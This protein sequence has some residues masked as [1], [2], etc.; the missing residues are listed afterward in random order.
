MNPG[1]WHI[2]SVAAAQPHRVAF[3][4]DVFNLENPTLAAAFASPSADRHEVVAQAAPAK[5]FVVLDE[6]AAAAD[7]TLISR[8]EQRFARG[9][10]P[11]LAA[12]LKLPGGEASKNDPAHLDT[13]YRAMLDCG[14]DRRS[15]VLAI[16]GGA[17]LDTAG[18]AAATMH[19]GVRL[20]RLPTTTLAQCDSGVGVKNAVNRFGVK[21][22]TGTFAVPWAVVN[23]SRFLRTLPDDVWR[24]GFAEVVKVA[25][26]KDAELFCWLEEHADALA[27]RDEPLAEHAWQRSAALHLQ[28]IAEAPPDGGGDPF[29]AD[30]ARPLDFGHW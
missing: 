10:L 8:I 7:F 29:E 5:T 13:L 2:R 6:N 17:L 22:A 14:I 12:T 15:Y 26:L 16:G 1:S 30:Q 23:D 28:H 3:A 25:L 18:Y 20:I 9:D 19:R 27:C 24:H 4:Q 11:P 21:N